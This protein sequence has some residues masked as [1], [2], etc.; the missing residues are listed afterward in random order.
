MSELKASESSLKRNLLIYMFCGDLGL[1]RVF[2]EYCL[3]LSVDA[4]LGGSSCHH[5]M[6]RP[7]VADGRDGHQLEVCCEYIE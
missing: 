5:G 3:L 7:R 1:R 4:M 6:A 2:L